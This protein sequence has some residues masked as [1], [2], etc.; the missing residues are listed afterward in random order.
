MPLLSIEKNKTDQRDAATA[1]TI[2]PAT[3]PQLR[4]SNRRHSPGWSG[5]EAHR[6]P[7][8][9]RHRGW[10]DQPFYRQNDGKSPPPNRAI[11]STLTEIMREIQ[12]R[13]IADVVATAEP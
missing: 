4:P 9:A 2:T 10:A 5:E 13:G 1:L 11:R 6:P 3:S 8:S 12:P 7:L